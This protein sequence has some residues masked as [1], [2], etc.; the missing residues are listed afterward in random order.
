[1]HDLRGLN[2]ENIAKPLPPLGCWR[3]HALRQR[4]FFAQYIRESPGA[5]I[6]LG[7]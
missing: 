1:M 6:V 2:M 5:A 4:D 3:Q 7:R